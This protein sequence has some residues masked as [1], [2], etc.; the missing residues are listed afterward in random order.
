MK[1]NLGCGNDIIPGW[2]NV[3]KGYSH[4]SPEFV[5]AVDIETYLAGLPDNT[6]THVKAHHVLEH[7]AD[8]D[9]MMKELHR[10]CVSGA[11]IDI[12]VPLANTLWAV[13]NPDHKRIFNHRTFQYYTHDFDTSDLGLF[14]GFSIMSQK[15]DREPNE[16]FGGIEW[17]VANLRVMLEV[18]K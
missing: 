3:D 15:V 11:T 13:A 4:N 7:I 12:V 18:V 5:I 1:A 14:R 17:I 8:L 10:V 16:W 6:L 2:D 9:S